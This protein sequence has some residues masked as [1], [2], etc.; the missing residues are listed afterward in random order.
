M[1]IFIV[2][3]AAMAVA[4]STTLAQR[5]SPTETTAFVA[6]AASANAFE[7]SD[8]AKEQAKSSE[9]KSFAKRMI[10]DHTKVGQALKAAVQAAN[11]S[12]LPANVPDS[13]QKS[14]LS[15]LRRIHGTAFD[16]P[17]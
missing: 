17:M 5:K 10:V 14:I 9:V 13:K 6:K 1:K 15:N 8:L 3:V 2:A 7:M 16:R 11:V 4:G 12:P